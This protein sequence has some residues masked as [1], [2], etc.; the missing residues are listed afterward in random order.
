MVYG[1]QQFEM[2]ASFLGSAKSG[3][4]YIP[5]DVNS[6]EERLT[7]II[8]IAKPAVILAIDELP[9]SISDILMIDK[10][11]LIV[12]FLRMYLMN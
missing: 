10:Q 8:E 11:H 1:G 2:I 7:D 6:S 5:V 9:T 3:H 4:A 12:Y